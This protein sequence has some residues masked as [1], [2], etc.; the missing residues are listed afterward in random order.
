MEKS[1]VTLRRPN[2]SVTKCFENTIL[3]YLPKSES[4][5][6]LTKYCPGGVVYVHAYVVVLSLPATEE[7]GAMGREI[8]SRYSIEW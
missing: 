3:K 6:I 8:E 4:L 5:T 2:F 1:V 7:T